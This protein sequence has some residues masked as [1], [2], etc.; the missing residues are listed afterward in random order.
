MKVQ[1]TKY[2]KNI[3]KCLCKNLAR[4][5]GS[6]DSLQLAQKKRM[7]EEV[8]WAFP[9]YSSGRCWEKHWRKDM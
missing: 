3:L 6:R 2:D 4:S 7:L 9:K 8:V 5:S 1:R